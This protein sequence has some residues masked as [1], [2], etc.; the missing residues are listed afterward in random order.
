MPYIMQE[1][2]SYYD[3]P[4]ED[5]TF[6]L[7]QEGWNAGHVTYILYRIV[8]QWFK[9]V[10]SYATIAN[11]RGCLVGTMTEFDRREAAPY[12]DSKIEDNGDV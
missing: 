1:H 12:E 8:L 10:P 9:D 3:K 6:T 4:L 11:I 5:L 7:G 2:R